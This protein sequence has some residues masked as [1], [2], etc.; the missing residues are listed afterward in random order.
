MKPLVDS[1][2]K[3]IHRLTVDEMWEM[4][5]GLYRFGCPLVHLKCGENLRKAAKM[6]SIWWRRLVRSGAKMKA[7]QAD[8]WGHVGS[9]SL[10]E[11]TVEKMDAD[12][13]W[14]P[15]GDWG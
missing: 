6:S 5:D 8:W 1:N 12:K 14:I 15:V 9:M 11:V 4:A 10:S 3:I 13:R 2:G 7:H